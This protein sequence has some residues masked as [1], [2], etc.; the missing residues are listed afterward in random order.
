MNDTHT[1]IFHN[2]HDA[3]VQLALRLKK[4]EDSNAIVLSIPRGGVI[5]GYEIARVLRKPMDIVVVRKIGAPQNPELGIAAITEGNIVLSDEVQISSIGI[6]RDQLEDLIYREKAELARRIEKYKGSQSLPPLHNRIVIIADDGLATGITIRACIKAISLQQPAQIIVAIPVCE[7]S[8]IAEIR[9][10]VSD[11]ICLE[12]PSNFESVGK[13]YRN[14]D[15]VSDDEVITYL[16]N[17]KLYSVS[18]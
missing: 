16:T 12:S 5:I 13:W 9:P 14:F 18:S 1:W 3:G 7:N 11:I 2:R 8:Q 10:E 4:F 6:T 15:P 17:A